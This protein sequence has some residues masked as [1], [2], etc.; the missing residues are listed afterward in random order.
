VSTPGYRAL[1]VAN[2]TYPNDAHNLPDLE[3][4]R[5]DPALLRD[6]L[7]DDRYGLFAADDVRLVVERTMAE[8]LRE[9]EEFLRTAQRH[10]TLL[11]YYSGH[12]KLD[13]GGQLYLCARDTRADRLRSTA[14]KASDLSAMIDESAAA[15]TVIMLDCCHSGAFKGGELTEA[16]AGRGRFVVTSCRTGELANDS[17][18]LNRASMFT[19]HVV[20]GMLGGAPD[21]DGDGLVGLNDL[22]GYVHARLTADHRQIPQRSFAGTGDVPVARR[23]GGP[24]TVP[25]AGPDPVLA[26][27]DTTID[28][29]EVD[30]G[31][32]LPPERIAVM[33]RGGGELR[34]SAD[35]VAPWVTL[36]RDEHGLLLHLRPGPGTNRANVH[37]RDD[38]TGMVTT[39][40]L[41]IRT[42]APAA[43]PAVPPEPAQPAE[44]AAPPAETEEPIEP[45]PV[46]NA[47]VPPRPAEATEAAG[48]EPEGATTAD[49]WPVSRWF[50][51]G[52][53]TTVVFGAWLALS[54][55]QFV[56]DVDKAFDRQVF[57]RDW[58]Y[59]P[60]LGTSILAGLA[61]AGVAGLAL[62]GHLRR[63]GTTRAWQRLRLGFAV[64]LAAALVVERVMMSFRW[65][66]HDDFLAGRSATFA[67]LSLVL[68]LATAGVCGYVLRADGGLAPRE[69][70]AP[71]WLLPVG[72]L[73]ALAWGVG[74]AIPV[75]SSSAYTRSYFDVTGNPDDGTDTVA[76][77]GVTVT[78]LLLVGVLAGAVVLAAR[79]VGPDAGRGLIA[80]TATFLVALEAIEL[81]TSFRSDEHH[82]G[83]GIVYMLLPAFVYVAA[84]VAA[85]R[86]PVTV[87]VSD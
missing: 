25:P 81:A 34:W 47:V 77:V 3:G 74:S 46:P 36:A 42:R 33:N 11:L 20:A 6:A 84:V 71:S 5:N 44:T 56:A 4:P 73:S 21:H 15:T 38:R 45:A 18:T 24:A 37:V 57:L 70:W 51:A 87:A 9:A 83:P 17:H 66:Q 8:V 63:A 80:G 67:F 75:I 30:A 54:G 82:Q 22:Y 35:C 76:V 2:S 19:H 60:G 27:S 41:V 61:L 10:D 78:M 58:D 29:G 85:L 48:P 86:R 12:G 32:D 49:R 43:E 69:Q 55:M 52:M 39:V 23:P 14:V 72:V 1:L 59:G 64:G 31:E 13:L 62:I 28:L 53:G 65:S 26:V 50:R 7:C 16:L 79:R 40:R 68:G